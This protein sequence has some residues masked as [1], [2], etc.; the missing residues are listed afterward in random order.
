MTSETLFWQ[1][2]KCECDSPIFEIEY[3]FESIYLEVES[4]SLPHTFP[5]LQLPTCPLTTAHLLSSPPTA[6]EAFQRTE[7]VSIFPVC[8]LSTFALA[9]PRTHFSH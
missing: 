7:P 4:K 5:S 3:N 2:K 6:F 1:G 9:I 8:Q